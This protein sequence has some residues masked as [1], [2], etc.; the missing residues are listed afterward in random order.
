MAYSI[1]HLQAAH[2]GAERSAIVHGLWDGVRGHLGQ[3]AAYQRDAGEYG[4][5]DGA[6][7]VIPEVADSG[8]P[9]SDKGS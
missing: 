7:Q 2:S 1:R 8:S 9:Q 6:G 5:V 3:N 4:R